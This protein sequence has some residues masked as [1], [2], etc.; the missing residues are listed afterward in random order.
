MGICKCPSGQHEINDSCILLINNPGESCQSGEI[1][2][3]GSFCSFGVCMCKADYHIVENQCERI[4]IRRRAPK[5]KKNNNKI[6]KFL[7]V[8]NDDVKEEKTIKKSSTTPPGHLCIKGEACTG[9]S[10]CKNGYCT[11]AGDEMIINDKCV[12]SNGEALQVFNLI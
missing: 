7:Q 11:C 5:I 9:G 6:P 4:G 1:C 2:G 10:V 8:A 12:N 3:K